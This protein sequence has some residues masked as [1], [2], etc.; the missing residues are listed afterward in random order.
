MRGGSLFLRNAILALTGVICLVLPFRSCA[1]TAASGARRLAGCPE[2]QAA[3]GFYRVARLPDGRWWMFNPSGQAI[4]PLGIDQ[5]RYEG[6]TSQASGKSG[7]HQSNLV[8][9]RGREEWE[10]DTLRR[11]K[12]MGF[13]ILAQGCDLT[14]RERG[15]AHTHY[16]AMGTRLCLKDQS[17]DRYI[18]PSR[19]GGA[20]P[21]VFHPDFS[22]WCD[23]QAKMECA[24]NMNDPWLVGYFIDNELE[25]NGFVEERTGLFD[26]VDKLPDSHSA[27]T[28]LLKFLSG[29]GIVSGGDVDLSVKRD[30]LRLVAETYFKTTTE[31]IRRHDPNHMIMGAR[32][33]GLHGADEIVWEIAGRYCDVVSFN[34][35][36]WVD[37]DRNAVMVREGRNAPRLADELAKKYSVC[38]RPMFVTEWSF[39]ALDS[40]LPCTSGAGQRFVTQQQRARASELFAKTILAQPFML[41]YNFFM[42]VDMPAEGTYV[43]S[44]ENS[45]YGLVSNKGEF[46]TEMVGMFTRLH[47]KAGLWRS[48]P[49]PAEFAEP[50][51]EDGTCTSERFMVRYNA[52]FKKPS[53]VEFARDDVSFV[54][55]NACGMTLAGR[56]GGKKAVEKVGCQGKELGSFNGMLRLMQDGKHRYIEATRVADVGWRET[57]GRGILSVST[58]GCR[59]NMKF[60]LTMDFTLF[61]EKP[62]FMCNLARVDNIGTEKFDVDAFLFRQMPS[63]PVELRN[64]EGRRIPHLWKG[65]NNATWYRKDGKEAWEG[66]TFSPLKTAMRYWLS[67]EGNPTPDVLF[68]PFKIME[69]APAGVYMPQGGMWML[70]VYRP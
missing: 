1:A 49:P 6:I 69:I 43:T 50:C 27:K 31:A 2:N 30:F 62:W 65:P 17:P 61:P 54:V 10:A 45:N 34:C 26:I 32:F 25:W 21:N 67:K 41:G 24:P 20:F 68:S 39:P 66:V 56:I 55:K 48:S 64:G 36:P 7:Y 63:F 3:T 58:E 28:A 51:Y 4:V 19:P 15:L 35:Y 18:C 33:A 70:A 37:L 47:S 38:G 52:E 60:R 16:L 14:L 23:A 11:L 59:G 40:G 53:K 44:P 12:S 42:W 46:Y 57:D 8:R 29:R 22:A 13:N 5:A 9:F